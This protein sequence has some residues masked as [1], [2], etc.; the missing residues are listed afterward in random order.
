MKDE[1][2]KGAQALARYRAHLAVCK[3]RVSSKELEPADLAL[4]NTIENLSQSGL[5]QV[6]DES[7]S[8]K[9]T[10][11]DK[12]RL[13][14][15]TRGLHSTVDKVIR[16]DFEL[17]VKRLTIEVETLSD[18]TTGAS[19]RYDLSEIGPTKNSFT[20][21]TI[22]NLISLQLGYFLPPNRMANLFALPQFSDVSIYRQMESQATEFLPLYLHMG[23]SL[24]DADHLQFD[25]TVPQVKEM[26]KMAASNFTLPTSQAKKSLIEMIETEFGRFSPKANGQGLQKKINLTCVIG[27]T[28]SEDPR[29]E[30]YFYRTHYGHAGNLVEKILENRLPQNKKLGLQGDLANWNKPSDD[31]K[32]RFETTFFGCTAHARRPFKLHSAEDNGLCDQMLLYF[33]YLTKMEKRIDQRGRTKKRVL[34]YRNRYGRKIWKKILNLATSVK[35]ARKFSQCEGHLLWPPRSKMG[36][37]C[38]Y[39]VNHY[40][41]LTAYLDYPT[42]NPDN[43]K[44][45]R[46]LRPEKL[47]LANSK[48]KGTEWARICLD[49]LRTQYMTC[50]TVG[51]SYKDYLKFIYKNR[52][53]IKENPEQY[54]PFA[55]AKLVEIQKANVTVSNTG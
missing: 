13:F 42:V 31:L 22:S 9:F 28:V 7:L 35:V 16:Y 40:E 54:T 43:N 15:K 48:Y 21:G 20:W 34:Y 37:A 2:Q 45:E 25:D 51:V 18:F 3:E 44:V 53:Q 23:T 29:S 19:F 11:E 5:V 30:I 26:S 52:E 39:I 50:I 41:E 32:S 46:L 27:R 6:V 24:A 10:T 38:N 47:F 33:L 4:A 49:I 14:G 17:N 1:A 8:L 12:L 36:T 55:Y